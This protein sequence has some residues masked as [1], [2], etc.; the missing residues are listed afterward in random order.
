MSITFH[1]ALTARS[2][3]D[4]HQ[5]LATALGGAQGLA[6]LATLPAAS[7]DAP[8]VEINITPRAETAVPVETAPSETDPPA[9]EEAPKRRR[10]TKAEIQAA[11]EA[12]M[13]AQAAADPTVVE[14]AQEAVEA[15]PAKSA[16]EAA[17]VLAPAVR[18]VAS[19]S[20]GGQ[21]FNLTRNEVL[22]VARTFIASHP[23]GKDRGAAVIKGI[24]ASHGFGKLSDVPDDLMQDV[25]DAINEAKS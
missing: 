15:P 24:A 7:A 6:W 11:E 8:P 2:L 12:E 5:Q 23:Q 21:T 25:L 4:L 3:A 20:D 19:W 10:R 14:A 1:I 13:A 9:A 16:A 22:D 18:T 17:E